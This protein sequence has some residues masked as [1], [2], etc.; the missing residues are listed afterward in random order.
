MFPTKTHFVVGSLHDHYVELANAVSD[1][2]LFDLPDVTVIENHFRRCAALIVDE[3]AFMDALIA[4]VCNETNRTGARDQSCPQPS[5]LLVAA[6][7]SGQRAGRFTTEFP[8]SELAAMMT[9]ALLLRCFTRR[10]L[11]AEENA[12]FVRAMVVDGVLTR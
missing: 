11:P 3:P 2:M 12:R 4:V 6:V 9:N 5:R 7:E 1:D 10:S 8:T